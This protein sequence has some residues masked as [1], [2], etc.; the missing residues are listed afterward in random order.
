MYFSS[1]AYAPRWRGVNPSQSNGFSATKT[2]T[3]GAGPSR[4]SQRK[5][6]PVVCHLSLYTEQWFSTSTH[7]H[8]FITEPCSRLTRGFLFL[9]GRGRRFS[10][11]AVWRRIAGIGCDYPLAE[12]QRR[13]MMRTMPGDHHQ[14]TI[15]RCVQLEE[16]GLVGNEQ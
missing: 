3:N 4:Q 5:G 12:R 9:S 10:E 16:P 1:C 13:V 15:I 2:G 6:L 14:A 7:H 8:L 11:S